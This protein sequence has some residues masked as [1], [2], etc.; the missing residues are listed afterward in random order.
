MSNPGV[1]V[2]MGVEGSGK[3]TVAAALAHRLG[4][5]FVEGDGLQPPENVAQMREGHP[6]T[7]A[8]R[9]PWLTAVGRV[10]ERDH[11]G[12]VAT[13]SALKRTYRDV[14]R[15]FAPDA[16]FVFLRGDEALIAR[17]IAGRQH[18][19]MPGSLL[20]SKLAILEPLGRDEHGVAV[21][22]TVPSDRIVDRVLA[23]LA[24]REGPARGG[25]AA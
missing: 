2:V 13:C 24:H 17:R 21:D 16:F 19:Y 9:M 18:E 23:A 14:L 3:S 10:L 6:L 4:V 22:V 1:I 11:E 7:D 12:V 25:S 5:P 15:G 8:E 20:A